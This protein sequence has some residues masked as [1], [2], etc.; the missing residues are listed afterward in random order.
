MQ[1]VGKVVSLLGGTADAEVG[2]T[3]R[4]QP[5]CERQRRWGEVYD[6]LA[7][8]RLRKVQHHIDRQGMEIDGKL[9]IFDG[10]VLR[11]STGSWG[12]ICNSC[13][14][15]S[16]AFV[17]LTVRLTLAASKHE[18]LAKIQLLGNLGERRQRSE[19]I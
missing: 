4:N 17:L 14:I 10:L 3:R 7:I 19:D 1:L 13:V 8:V 2:D 15:V 5:M 16:I 12:R 6:V 11:V 9:L 18:T